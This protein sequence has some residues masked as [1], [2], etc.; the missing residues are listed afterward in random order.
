[1]SDTEV[2][3]THERAHVDSTPMFSKD[4]LLFMYHVQRQLLENVVTNNKDVSANV[5]S[6]IKLLKRAL[7]AG[8]YECYQW[9][10]KKNGKCVNLTC[11]NG[12]HLA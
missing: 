5:S 3:H 12:L 7:P 8:S 9:D 2:A 4:E 1:M 6:I 10:D 11:D